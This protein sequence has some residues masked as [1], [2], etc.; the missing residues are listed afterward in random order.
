MYHWILL[1]ALALALSCGLPEAS[2]GD[3]TQWANAVPSQSGHRGWA[4]S[5]DEPSDPG[6]Q[7]IGAT[8]TTPTTFTL[9]TP[10]LRLKD[11]RPDSDAPTTQGL[12]SSTSLLN[13]FVVAE[14]EVARNNDAHHASRPW[15]RSSQ[16]MLRVSLSGDYGPV[17]YGLSYRHADRQ[18]LNAPDQELR[19]LWGEWSHGL[20][21]LRTSVTELSTNVE[22]DPTRPQLSQS[23]SRMMMSVA[24]PDWPE[25]S[26]SFA[27]TSLDNQ[28]QQSGLMSQRLVANVVEGAI[29]VTR[30]SWN[31]RLATSYSQG[32]NPFQPSEETL[33]YTQMFTGAFHPIEPLSITSVI[34]YKTDVQQWTGIRTD[35]PVASL[36]VHYRHSTRWTITAMGGYTGLRTSDGMTEN[37]TLNSKG[38]ITWSPWGSSVH[39]VS[40]ETGYS[41]T[42]LG[43]VN[44]SGM[45]TEDLSG[46][47]K[48]RVTQF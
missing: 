48:L 28:A 36:A 11:L 4:A 43:G 37:E 29:A 22:S 14:S 32:A 24:R 40:F 18:F 13:G 5:T 16:S 20:I 8:T 25:L 3:L 44:G 6:F 30:T 42:V 41:R 31:A 1:A 17:R 21:R 34:S 38:V 46:L 10:Y 26:L 35:T 33:S 23:T 27:R 12:R 45:V 19:E 39:Q 15:D 9:P 47:V 2:A 7:W